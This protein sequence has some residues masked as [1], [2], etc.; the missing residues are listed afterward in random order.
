MQTLR[1]YPVIEIWIIK[2]EPG[3]RHHM[4]IRYRPARTTT[5]RAPNIS[6]YVTRKQ[7]VKLIL[8]KF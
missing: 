3:V 2:E 6:R 1:T 5:G 7:T 4:V 8:F